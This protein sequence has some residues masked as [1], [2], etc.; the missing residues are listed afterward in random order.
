MY[1][2]T[3]SCGISV[4]KPPREDLLQGVFL[5]LCLIRARS[6]KDDCRESECAGRWRMRAMRKIIVRSLRLLIEA[7][8]LGLEESK[9][10]NN[11]AGIDVVQKG[12]RDHR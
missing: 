3:K 11:V 12:T 6:S 9:G 1:K 10:A 5:G 4:G 7:K 2:I 8:S